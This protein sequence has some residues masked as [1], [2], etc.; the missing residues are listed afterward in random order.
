M[1]RARRLVPNVEKLAPN[2][3]AL[4]RATLAAIQAWWDNGKQQN[5]M[6][7]SKSRVRIAVD[8]AH[9]VGLSDRTRAILWL[10]SD[11]SPT[12]G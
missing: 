4:A 6:E 10:P 8:D 2:V 7:L 11:F 9:G 3:T 5:R 1:G 12:G